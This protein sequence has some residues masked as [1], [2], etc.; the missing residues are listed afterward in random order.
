[1]EVHSCLIEANKC[2]G[3]VAIWLCGRNLRVIDLRTVLIKQMLIEVGGLAPIEAEHT[4]HP[5]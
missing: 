4:L 1:M 3:V 2:T 5:S